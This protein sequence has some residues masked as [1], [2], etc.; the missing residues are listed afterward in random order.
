MLRPGVKDIAL[1]HEEGER[2]VEKGGK[3][4]GKSG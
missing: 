4:E 2:S 1:P 3:D